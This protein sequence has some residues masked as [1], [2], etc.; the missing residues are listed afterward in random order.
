MRAG[1]ARSFAHICSEGARVT[2]AGMLNAHPK[3]RRRDPG[4]GVRTANIMQ[5]PG[6]GRASALAG[7]TSRLKTRGS[8]AQGTRAP[9]LIGCGLR[10]QSSEWSVARATPES[11]SKCLS[12]LRSAGRPIGSAPQYQCGRVGREQRRGMRARILALGARPC[13]AGRPRLGLC[14]ARP[15]REHW[16]RRPRGRK[17]PRVRGFPKALPARPAPGPCNTENRNARGPRA[18]SRPHARG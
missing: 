15:V 9:A 2:R 1:I 18:P 13:R 17:R 3:T 14:P 12:A 5:G 11:T 6:A 8:Y 4:A 10:P 16:R 7:N